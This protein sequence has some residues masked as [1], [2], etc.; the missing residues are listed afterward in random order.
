MWGGF[1]IAA[2]IGLITAWW[3]T[4]GQKNAYLEVIEGLDK[5]K[6]FNLDQ[7]AIH[8][9]AIAVDGGNKNEI[10]LRDLERQISR[11]HCEI[12]RR[13]GKFF[14]IDCNSANGTRVDG[15][16]AEAG[17]PVRL[18]SG[19]RITLASTCALRLGWEKKKTT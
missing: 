13:N 6:K 4:R 5:G 14:L 1:G 17:R 11:F 9:G 8:L 3:A 10:V 2:L 12:H 15:K 7:D 18:K 19:A 16:R